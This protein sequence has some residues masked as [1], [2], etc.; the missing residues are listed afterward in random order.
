MTRELQRITEM[1]W[2]GTVLEPVIRQGD[3]GLP[4]DNPLRNG[5]VFC[6]RSS[7]WRR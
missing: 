1:N 7:R 4:P 3:P 5:L 2:P 6:Q